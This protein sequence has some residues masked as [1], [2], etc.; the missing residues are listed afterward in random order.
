[1]NSS[2]KAR[3]INNLI[4]MLLLCV[5]WPMLSTTNAVA[6]EPAAAN[7]TQAFGID[8]QADRWR[9]SLRGHVITDYVFAD[10]KILRP[11]FA[12]IRLVDGL[13]VTRNHPPVAGTDAVDHDTMHPGMWI[14]LG[15]VNGFDFWRNKSAIVHERFI[16]DPIADGNTLSFA[17]QSR[18]MQSEDQQ[19][20]TMLCRYRLSERPQGWMLVWETEI[21]PLQQTIV[22]GDQEEM[23]VG[24]RVA[25][26]LTEKNGGQITSSTGNVGSAKTWGQLAD[27]C[28]YSGYLNRTTSRKFDAA[29]HSCRHP[30]TFA[31]VGGTTGIT[32]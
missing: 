27:W 2:H 26:P 25:T 7:S 19:L 21:K 18:M 30:R 12:N 20:A 32:D 8:K 28:D 15:S 10:P 5:A 29:S 4:Q 23:G 3:R 6:Q 9:L 13:Q 14:G 1:M 22:L 16:D 11:H 24:V 17:T 31:L